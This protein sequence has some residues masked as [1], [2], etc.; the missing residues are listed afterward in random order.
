MNWPWRPPGRTT[1]GAVRTGECI[2]GS[3][4]WQVT[5]RRV[6]RPLASGKRRRGRAPD[7]VGTGRPTRRSAWRAGASLKP[8]CRVK[9]IFWI[10]C[11]PLT[12]SAL[13]PQN[14]LQPVKRRRAL[15]ASNPP[16]NS[17]SEADLNDTGGGCESPLLL[18]GFPN[19]FPMPEKRTAGAGQDRRVGA[20]QRSAGWRFTNYCHS[21]Y[22][23]IFNLYLLKCFLLNAD[24]VGGED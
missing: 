2:K 9:P 19:S 14:G 16:R 7:F 13:R 1:S 11:S 15:L 24:P 6:R 3:G 17:R 20:R 18:L 12:N 23:H 10:S 22:L 4:E 8:R 5:S 21:V